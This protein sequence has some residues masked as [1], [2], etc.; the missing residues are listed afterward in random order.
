MI[1]SRDKADKD[2]FKEGFKVK[3]KEKVLINLEKF[4]I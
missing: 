4:S 3:G 1:L 2:K